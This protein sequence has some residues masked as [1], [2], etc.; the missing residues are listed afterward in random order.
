MTDNR[1]EEIKK[2]LEGNAYFV[3]PHSD[4]NVAVDMRF[5]LGLLDERDKKIAG[6]EK[7]NEVLTHQLMEL[8]TE[9]E[10]VKSDF[11]NSR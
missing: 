10:N 9:I 7:K 4:A 8:T 3:N 2:R 5:L 6:L 1:I 11:G